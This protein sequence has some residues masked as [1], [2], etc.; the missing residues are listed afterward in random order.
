VGANPNQA[1]FD[2]AATLHRAGD[3]SHAFEL[4]RGLRTR[5]PSDF[6][7]LHLGGV[8]LVQLGR[9][10]DAE[11]WLRAALR[12]QPRSGTTR[13]CLGLA[14][15]G[16]GRI[17]DAEKELREAVR[18]DPSSGEATGNLGLL[19]LH[20]GRTDEGL[21]LLRK[22]TGLEPASTDAR[23]AL[24]NA[25]V[26][27]GRAQEA[28]GVLDDAVRSSPRHAPCL[29]ARAQAHFALNRPAEALADFTAALALDPND[30]RAASYR[31]LLL[32]Y[33]GEL[34]PQALAEEHRAFGRRFP[35]SPR[36][37]RKPSADGR[38]TVAFLSPDLRSHAVAFFLE[39]LL[40]H[41]D[42]SRF[43]VL[44]YHDHFVEDAVSAR[45]RGMAD[46]W[47]NLVGRPDAEVLA[48]IR[49]DAPDMLVD[50]AGHTGFNRMAVFAARAAPVQVSYLGYPNTTGLPAM[51]ARLTDPI[52]DPAGTEGLH[53]ESLVRFSETA[54]CYRPPPSAPAVTPPPLLTHGTAP[55]FGSFNN[56]SKVSPAT[57]RLWTQLLAARP[58][59]RLLLKGVEPHPGWV[60]RHLLGSGITP[61]QVTLLPPTASFE[62]HLS[63]YAGMDLALDTFPYHGTT[64]TCEALWM[65]RPVV[66][67]AGTSH[68]SRVGASVLTAVGLSDLVATDEAGYVQAALALANDPSRLAALSASLRERLL[69]SPLLDGPRQSALFWNA[70]ATCATG[71]P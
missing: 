40:M 27:L 12:L 5:T 32:H 42:R 6:R 55:V 64:T 48:R 61:E 47:T 71:T 59:A 65:G 31:L 69:G 50:L 39:P 11:G 2:Q 63:A 51:E 17:P 18:L 38:L 43:R 25:L 49:A 10:A 45:L 9:H 36:L 58:G 57:W 60:A 53:T 13:M 15:Q 68:V 66:S 8:A 24:G 23:V 67:L 19:L 34:S 41:V 30:L 37:A 7:V 16:L 35:P 20:S 28:L 62:A 21:S 22:R 52:A 46:A 29:T 3:L 70:L 26:S 14:L 1:L 4:Y 54:W 44:L 56:L 33:A